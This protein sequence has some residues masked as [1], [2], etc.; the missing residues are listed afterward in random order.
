MLWAAVNIPPIAPLS[1][2]SPMGGGQT[3]MMTTFM[4]VFGVLAMFVVALVI[5]NTEAEKRVIAAEAEA[6]EIKVLAEANAESNRILTESL[7]ELLL[8]YQT[9]QK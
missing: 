3:S 6:S 4:M 7:T 8:Q 2:A 1:T 5:A 9:V